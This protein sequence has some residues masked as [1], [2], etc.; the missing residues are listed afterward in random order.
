MVQKIFSD[1]A[2]FGYTPKKKILWHWLVQTSLQYSVEDF[3]KIVKISLQRPKTIQIFP[4]VYGKFR[5]NTRV[6]Q[7]LS[8]VNKA[9]F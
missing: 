5:K 1:G 8:Y 2:F 6:F 9:K 3:G 7:M 4:T